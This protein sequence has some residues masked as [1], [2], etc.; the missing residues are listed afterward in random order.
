M[1]M[2]SEE[3]KNKEKTDNDRDK[4]SEY[5][6]NESKMTNSPDQPSNNSNLIVKITPL[7]EEIASL[8]DY[9]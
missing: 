6:I 4:I 9:F 8:K 1:I 3:E 2:S 5:A 7:T